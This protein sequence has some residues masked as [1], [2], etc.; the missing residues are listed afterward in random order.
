MSGAPSRAPLIAT[1][2]RPL[3]ASG[4]TES[5]PVTGVADPHDD[6]LR[7]D[8]VAAAM[9]LLDLMTP[10]FYLV[11]GR[12]WLRYMITIIVVLIVIHYIPA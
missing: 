12:P 10:A 6:G 7:P 2:N 1:I 3:V 11:S 4:R 5:R 8:L 9:R